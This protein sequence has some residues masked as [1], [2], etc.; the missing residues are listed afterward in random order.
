MSWCSLESPSH[1]SLSLCFSHQ[2]HEPDVELAK[3]RKK[4]MF[5]LRSSEL[6]LNIIFPFSSSEAVWIPSPFGGSGVN[7]CSHVTIH[8]C[9]EQAY[10]TS[11]GWVPGFYICQTINSPSYCF[12]YHN[13]YSPFSAAKYFLFSLFSD[14]FIKIHLLLLV[15]PLYPFLLLWDQ[16]ITETLCSVMNVWEAAL[17]QFNQTGEIKVSQLMS[18]KELV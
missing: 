5:G 4:I 15:L 13:P 8:A 11:W 12:A 17:S 18:S 10:A 6:V 2:C 3:K 7:T 14:C 16:T 1:T 9:K